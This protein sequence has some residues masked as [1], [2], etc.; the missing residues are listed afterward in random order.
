MADLAPEGP[1]YLEP[2]EQEEA[3][4][5]VLRYQLRELED[6][7]PQLHYLEYD[8]DDHLLPTIV[9]EP[10]RIRGVGGTTM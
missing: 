4:E 5:R 10:I 7:A 6:P 2:L 8:V 9:P 1:H 3:E